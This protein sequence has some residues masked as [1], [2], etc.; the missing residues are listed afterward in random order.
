MAK[1]IAKSCA[2]EYLSEIKDIDQI[3]HLFNCG[4]GMKGLAGDNDMREV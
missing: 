4:S 2:F 3:D 1:E